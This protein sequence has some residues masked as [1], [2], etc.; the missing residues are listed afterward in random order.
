MP[1]K[2]I[3]SYCSINFEPNDYLSAWVANVIAPAGYAYH[4]I[5]QV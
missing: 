3:Y 5:S 2:W 4:V 1:R